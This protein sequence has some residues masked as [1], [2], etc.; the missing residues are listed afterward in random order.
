M[1]GVGR[2]RLGEE[3]W[4]RI[5]GEQ[6]GVVTRA[7]LLDARCTEG[8]VGALLDNGRWTV[9]QRGVYAVFTGPVPPI[10]RIWA[11]VLAAGPDAV[12]GGEAALWLA[13]VPGTTPRHITVCV[14]W[15]R[16]ATAVKEVDVVRRRGLEALAHPAARPP[17][18]RIEEALLDLTDRCTREAA[19]VEVVFRVAPDRR[20]H[21]PGSGT[22]STAGRGYATVGCSPS[23]SARSPRACGPPSSG[24]TA[25]G[26]SAPTDSPVAAATP[27]NR[28]ST[29]VGVDAA[30]ATATSAT[31]AHASSSS[32][33]ASPR[34][35]CTSSTST[36]SATTAPSCPVCASCSSAG[37][38]SS[39]TR[40]RSPVTWR[41]CCGAKAGEAPPPPAPPP[42]RSPCFS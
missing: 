1:P 30:T 21:P 13:G 24:G 18:L 3:A 37:T 42:A 16:Q 31:S 20:T 23:W 39:T 41:S 33:T 15:E 6:A 29:S 4:R 27:S 14:P 19:V 40:A 28:S 5:A 8:Q 32:W 26:W 25:E 35:P 22:P 36:T 38:P 34:I 12:V 2:R 7:Q 17:R 11:A 9:L 10:S